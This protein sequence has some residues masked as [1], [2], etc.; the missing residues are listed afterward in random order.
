MIKDSWDR[1]DQ[2]LSEETENDTE[3]AVSHKSG[4]HGKGLDP[5]HPYSKRSNMAAQ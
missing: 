1:G 3:V 5:V 2:N 4:S